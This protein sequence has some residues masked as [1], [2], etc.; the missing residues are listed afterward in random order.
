VTEQ[1]TD[2]TGLSGKRPV[3]GGMVHAEK[4]GNIVTGFAV[5]DQLPGMGDVLRHQL[6]LAPEFHAPARRV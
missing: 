1:P 4:V 2:R 5:V 6:W 3:E